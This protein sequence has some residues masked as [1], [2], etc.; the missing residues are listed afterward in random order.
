MLE[1]QISKT[2]KILNERLVKL[3]RELKKNRIAIEAL[4]SICNHKFRR[5]SQDSEFNYYEC[6][7]CY[8]DK[9]EKK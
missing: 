6:E 5:Y 1:V 2:I 9:K 8:I 7:Y 3:E 4:Q